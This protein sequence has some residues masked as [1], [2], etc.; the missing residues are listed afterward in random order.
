MLKHQIDALK[1]DILSE[2]ILHTNNVTISEDDIKRQSVIEIKYRFAYMT[3][4]PIM[5]FLNLDD[6]NLDADENYQL[7]EIAGKVFEN[8]KEYRKLHASVEKH[9]LQKIMFEQVPLTFKEVSIN[10]FKKAEK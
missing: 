5:E 7:L 10:E 9:Y 2:D 4:T 6:I 8:E 1:A 3:Q